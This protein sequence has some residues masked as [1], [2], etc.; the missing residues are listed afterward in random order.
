M[1]ATKVRINFKT[2]DVEFEGSEE[3][4]KNQLGSIRSIVRLMALLPGESGEPNQDAL[5]ALNTDV[6]VPPKDELEVEKKFFLQGGLA[7]GDHTR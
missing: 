3:F 6:V 2:G 1:E 5:Q 7:N 4:V